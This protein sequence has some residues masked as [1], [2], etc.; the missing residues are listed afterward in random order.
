MAKRKIEWSP[1][2]LEDLSI[3]LNYYIERNGNKNYSKKLLAQIKKI[4]SFIRDNN[5]L[6]KATDDNKTRV[7]IYKN[8]KIFYE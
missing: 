7:L 8:Y 6:G 3:I 4:I 1:N 5:Y 2:A